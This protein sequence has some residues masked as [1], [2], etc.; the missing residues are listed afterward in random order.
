MLVFYVCSTFFGGEINVAG[1]RR[2]MFGGVWNVRVVI[3]VDNFRVAFCCCI[4]T[5]R[6]LGLVCICIFWC[7]L[8][9]FARF[10]MFRGGIG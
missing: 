1:L 6:V 7:D 5:C 10:M 3:N 4:S 2:G 8:P 9:R